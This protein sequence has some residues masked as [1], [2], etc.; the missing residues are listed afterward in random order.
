[1]L[2]NVHGEKNRHRGA[3][4]FD[5]DGTIADSF[6]YVFDFLKKEAMDTKTYSA[7][8][9]KTFR[10]MS[11]K[12]LAFAL[13]VPVWHMP[14]TYF[15][16]RR[17]MRAHMEHVQPFAGMVDVIRTLDTD[18]YRLFIASSNSG[19]NIRHL[20]R[21]QGVLGC[22]RTIR[23]S[24]GITGKPALI[25]GLLVQ[26]RLPKSST[27]YVGDEVGDIAAAGRAGVRSLAVGWGFAGPEKL[28][29][30][31]PDGFATKPTDIV[32]IIEA[33]WKK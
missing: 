12:D 4:I 20:L 14:T 16:G 28:K 22:F 31:H 1:M 18:G 15:R 6:E 19:H 23:S 3:V 21:R 24:A 7:S 29:V 17:V 11:M 5:F 13:G 9:I 30:A 25:R 33:S 32:Q 2:R 26:Y 27:W 8:E 10:T